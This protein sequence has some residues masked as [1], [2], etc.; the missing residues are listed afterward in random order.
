VRQRAFVTLEKFGDLALPILEKALDGKP[1][2][3]MRRRV[4]AL[5]QKLDQTPPAPACLPQMRALEALELIGTG[6]ARTFLEAL[7]RGEP[8]ALLTDQANA[9]CLRL[10]A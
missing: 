1:S 4:E 5:L 9:A 3:E 6:L 8:R 7:A 10:V 2:L